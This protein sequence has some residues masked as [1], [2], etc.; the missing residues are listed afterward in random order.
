MMPFRM[1]SVNMAVCVLF[2]PLSSFSLTACILNVNLNFLSLSLSLFLFH[3]ISLPPHLHKHTHIDINRLYLLLPET[4]FPPFTL[5]THI[6]LNNCVCVW[7]N[8]R[9]FPLILRKSRYRESKIKWASVEKK[10][11][12]LHT[13]PSSFVHVHPFFIHLSCDLNRPH[14]Y[15]PTCTIFFYILFS[16]QSKPRELLRKWV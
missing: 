11:K 5:H 13:H 7:A 12:N 15:T 10:N 14:R 1:A 6:Y 3:G 9:V 2:A 8:F 16:L 4:R